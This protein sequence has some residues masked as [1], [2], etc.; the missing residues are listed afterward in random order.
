V[1]DAAVRGVAVNDAVVRGVAVND[2]AEPGDAEA[3]DVPTLMIAH[4][5]H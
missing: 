1:T 2:A 3:G 5:R 4:F